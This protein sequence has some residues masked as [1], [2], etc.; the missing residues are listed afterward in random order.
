MAGSSGRLGSWLDSIFS[1]TSY[2]LKQTL[3]TSAS[4]L[5]AALSEPPI[6]IIF[7]DHKSPSLS[8][9]TV[10]AVL[11]NSAPDIPVVVISDQV[12]TPHDIAEL[13]EIGIDDLLLQ[14]S[15]SLHLPLILGRA[16]GRR[17]TAHQ[18]ADE[19]R[20]DG[21]L[22]LAGRSARFGGWSVDLESDRTVWSDQA[23]EICGLPPG[24]KSTVQEAFGLYAPEW[25]QRI[26]EVFRACAEDGTSYNE[27]VEIITPD[28]RRLWVRTVGEAVREEGGR[29]AEVRGAVQDITDRKHAEVM[30]QRLFN[31][32]TRTL[33]SITDAFFT[34]DHDWRFTNL[35]KQAETL[36]QRSRQDLI[37][38]VIWEEL[39]EAVDKPWSIKFNQ[40]VRER[41]LVTFE[42]YCAPLERWLDFKAYPMDVGL[43]VY[44]RDVT[45][46]KKAAERLR[47]LETSVAHLEE[48]IL[49]TSA[50]PL[51]EPGPE[52]LYVNP[53]F[54]RITGYAQEE[55]V[56]LTP[57]VL[58]G[59][60]TDRETRDRIK[61]ALRNGAPIRERLVNYSR[62]GEPYWIEASIVPIPD[63][64]GKITHFAA[65]E[66][67]ITEQQALHEQLRLASDSLNST[68]EGIIILDNDGRAVRVNEAYCGLTGYPAE[69]VLGKRIR[70][71]PESKDGET[72]FQR[73]L[74]LSEDQRRHHRET[75]IRRR[76]GE[77]F[78]V[79]TSVSAVRNDAGVETH[80]VVVIM[81]ITE[82]KAVE[83]RAEYLSHH[84][85]LTGLPNRALLH[86]RGDEGVKRARQGVKRARRGGHALGLLFLEI[87]RFKQINDS[88]GHAAGDSLLCDVAA[89]LLHS[90][91]DVDTVARL[92]GDEFTILLDTLSKP[93]DAD[94]VAL[95]ILKAFSDPFDIQDR[96]VFITV[97]IG[98]SQYP[99]DGQ[100][101]SAL[102]H[103]ADLAM[104]SAKDR[105]RDC[106]V[107]YARNMDSPSDTLTLQSALH[108]ALARD[109]FRLHYQPLIDL[110]SGRIVGAEALIRWHTPELGVVPPSDF[111]PLAEKTGLILPI[112][113]WVIQEAL[114]EMGEMQRAG[115]LGLRFAVNLSARQFR[116]TDLVETVGAL[117][118]ASNLAATALEVEI[119]ETMMMDRIAETM[120]SLRGF[121]AL[122]VGVSLDD[123]GTGY[124][125]LQY[126]KH[127]PIDRIKIDRS[128][129]SGIPHDVGDM[130]IIRTIIT[131]AHS[132]G[133]KVIA[134]G[135]ETEEQL[136]TLRKMGCVEAQGYFLSMPLQAD[137]LRWLIDNHQTLPVMTG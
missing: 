3:I 128:F 4:E 75:W 72:L 12:L 134:E 120:E 55:I 129:V 23:C 85:A 132:L 16:S 121:R 77:V 57:R 9:K 130:A 42:D 29:I 70:V 68:V 8:P 136:V 45:E 89:R 24:S 31:G 61:T 64:H 78:P 82:R 69:Q 53:A 110:Q 13:Q 106:Y 113:E 11:E 104:Y 126:L 102:M 47:L 90:V 73:I 111:I 105:G 35:N 56:G 18:E 58:Q 98:I 43:A 37:G 7:T 115:H 76:S 32:L 95:K 83:Q 135:V 124:S 25:R 14:E 26:A 41:R 107:H 112:G 36:L 79:L 15:A 21:F 5:T 123:F 131:M 71:D 108:Q 40:A 6:D 92:G 125:S 65:V 59:D 100:D 91:R 109:E 34:L 27:E 17:K 39:A 88:L 19:S 22:R 87:D 62:S 54:S 137:D 46:Q 81:D 118:K 28:E 84:D 30:A 10:M 86:K 80:Y 33:E 114:R 52:I 66:R 117:L 94:A 1:S 96:R 93:D 63:E 119:T 103:N 49:I 60:G 122:G 2:E 99:R 20:L 67:D 127:F 44:L 97:S 38:K 48:M 74:G 50:E 133:V 51:D 101:F 116:Q